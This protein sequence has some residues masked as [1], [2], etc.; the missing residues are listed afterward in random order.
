MR[1]PR[2]RP[3]PE[4]RASRRGGG[5]LPACSTARRRPR[6]LNRALRPPGGGSRRRLQGQRHGRSGSA[7][8]L[9]AVSHEPPHV[10][11]QEL[12][13]P[14]GMLLHPGAGELAPPRDASAP[15]L[16]RLLPG[17][18]GGR[19]WAPGQEPHPRFALWAKLLCS[20]QDT[21]RLPCPRRGRP[22]SPH[23]SV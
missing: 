12:A 20:A 23:P 13:V 18:D 16:E 7:P 2:P 10:H 19:G 15:A 3:L 1:L 11:L 22:T 6:G 17:P 9:A 5:A 8:D 21:G 14:G 4:G